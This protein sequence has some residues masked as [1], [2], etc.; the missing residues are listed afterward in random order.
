[1]DLSSLIIMVTI[2][3]SKLKITR[4]LK[5]FWETGPKFVTRQRKVNVSRTFVPRERNASCLGFHS[6]IYQALHCFMSAYMSDGLP[7]PISFVASVIVWHYVNTNKNVL[8]GGSSLLSWSST[9][10]ASRLKPS[11]INI[12]RGQLF[13]STVKATLGISRGWLLQ[14]RLVFPEIGC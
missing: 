5:I 13:Y 11:W 3:F 8:R 14:P 9:L 2:V 6:C 1:M 4:G 12:L 7:N 10:N